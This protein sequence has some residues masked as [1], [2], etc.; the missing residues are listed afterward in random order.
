MEKNDPSNEVRS[1]VGR[2]RI[3]SRVPDGSSARLQFPELGTLRA[4][5]V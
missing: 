3:A 4:A 1:R 5:E 2:E